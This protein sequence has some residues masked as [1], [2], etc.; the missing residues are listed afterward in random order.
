MSASAATAV[1]GHSGARSRPSLIP[2][3]AIVGAAATVTST[4]AVATS[5]ILSDPGR[6]AV[7]RGLLVAAYI[8]AGT[9]TWWRHPQN[10]FGLLIAGGGFLYAAVGLNA[11][12]KPLPFTV[13][14]LF[15]AAIVVYLAYVALCF[16]RDKLGSPLERRFVTGLTLATV[17]AWLPA[18]ALSD[19]L[20]GG[21]PLTDCADKCPANALLLWRAPEAV[22]RASLFAVG[23]VTA[24][25]IAVW[26]ILLLR[27]ARSRSHLRRQAF[28]PVLYGF[29]VM[30][31]SYALFGL[32]SHAT[33]GH[34]AVTLRITQA[35]SALVVPIALLAGHARGHLF[36]ATTLTELVSKVGGGPVTPPRAQSLIRDALGDP[37]LA[38]ALWA[39]ERLA[40]VDVN[41]GPTDLSAVDPA[42]RAIT[43]ID[44]DGR[45]AA[46]VIHDRSL[47]DAA[48][49]G[50]LAG[51]AL[52]LI[53]NTR[54]VE[55]LRA[56]RAR[57]IT[58]ADRERLTLERNLHDGAQQRLFALQLKLARLR[59][60]VAGD[61][62]AAI[63]DV[64]DDAAAAVDE[65]RDLAHGIYP[66]VLRE[67]GLGDALITAAQ[68]APR[69]L[70]VVDHGIGR[71][72]APIEAAV[73]F[74]SLEA[75]QNALKHA[76]PTAKITVTLGRGAGELSFAVSDD[77][78][79]FDLERRSDGL[80]LVSMRD[81]IGAI[82]GELEIFSF[83]RR[84]TTV[85]GT[86]PLVGG[87]EETRHTV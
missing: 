59:K 5:T 31:G 21:G 28:S 29:V 26:M 36:A 41:R 45:P 69:P 60:E 11:L 37:K 12:A 54:L 7:V 76:G 10:R 6:T 65:L 63:D 16:P 15:L 62:V 1:D 22:A 48:L 13:G 75:I 34:T 79:G 3:V 52:M 73:Y 38:L 46:A 27:K 8:G 57:M 64:A 67:R 53:E 4:Y 86:V 82:G 40:F 83:R 19:T 18:L 42:E 23:V 66:T 44:R 2:G 70:K 25:G 24:V 51:T 17:C 43:W 9:Y 84:G 68:S 32:L 61:L 39:P 71:C 14:R 20:P 49:V 35:A 85:R 81:R 80:G 33:I 30:G 87:E 78:S 47:D 77:G 72:S 50:G 58:A 55:E 56:S 74:C